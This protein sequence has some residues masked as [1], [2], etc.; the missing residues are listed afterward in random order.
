MANAGKF[1]L[2]KSVLFNLGV[3]TGVFIVLL[4]CS[5]FSWT[6]LDIFPSF[7]VTMVWIGAAYILWLAWKTLRIK[8]HAK[9]DVRVVK[10]NLYFNGIV[11]QFV[12]P[13]TILYGLTAFSS[14]ILPRFQAPIIL[15][16]FCILLSVASF[17]CTACWTVFGAV[18]QKFIAKHTMAVN[19]FLAVLLVYCAISLVLKTL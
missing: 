14:F 15:V 7:Q 3:S 5:F 10:G 11:L 6:L 9:D 16:A 4:I 12:N 13:N 19:V 8:S 1:G 2:K 18:F 17:I